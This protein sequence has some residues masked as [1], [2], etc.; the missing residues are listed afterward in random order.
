MTETV[1]FKRLRDG[2]YVE[3][4]SGIELIRGLDD[5]DGYDRHE[6]QI[7]AAGMT[8]CLGSRSTLSAAK[9]RA[10]EILGA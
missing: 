3:P 5:S 9:T 7:W 4:V 8:E 1:K 6:W 2:R 10:R